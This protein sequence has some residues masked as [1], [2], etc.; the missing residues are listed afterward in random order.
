MIGRSPPSVAIWRQT[1]RE[2]LI[3][4]R[5]ALPVEERR[6]LGQAISRQLEVTLGEVAGLLISAY[7]PFRGEPDLRELMSHLINRGSRIV[8]PVVVER[9]RP[10]T[11]REWMPGAPL[12]RGIW[13][14]PVPAEGAKE[15]RPDIVLAPVVG[16]DSACYRL[17]YG[18]GYYDRTL[19]SMTNGPRTLGV[20]YEMCALPTIRPQPH[21]IAMQAIVTEA[22]VV[23]PATTSS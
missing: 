12:E 19:A 13:N 14:I 16:F 4:A 5:L 2:R 6:R 11:F 22:R 23:T 9:A 20:G 21:D 1:E 3:A 17:G 15:F 10:L 18:G 8:L 7:W